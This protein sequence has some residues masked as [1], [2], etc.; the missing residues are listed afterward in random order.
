VVLV[1]QG[2][3]YIK[4]NK[5]NEIE[6]VSDLSQIR[7]FRKGMGDNIPRF[8]KLQ[9]TPFEHCYDYDHFKTLLSNIDDCKALMNMKL[10]PFKSWQVLREYQNNRELFNKK[11]THLKTL[12]LIDPDIN[13]YAYNY[14]ID[15]MQSANITYNQVKDNLDTIN[16]LGSRMFLSFLDHHRTSRIFVDYACDFKALIEWLTYTIKNR[17]RLVIDRYY[18]GNEYFNVG[19]YVDYLNSQYQMYGKIREKYPENWLTEKQIMNV[20]YTEWRTLKQ[21]AEFGLHQ[22]RLVDKVSFEDDLFKVV[23]PLTNTMILDE[24]EQQRHCV[25][26]YIDKVAQ[27]ET[28]IVFIRMKDNI[29]ESL[30]T[31][32]INNNNTICQVRGFQNRAY[33]RVEYDFM[34]KWAEAKKLTLGVPECRN[35]DCTN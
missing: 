27:G 25:A 8:K 21:N 28:H 26:S 14:I 32:E 10:N 33:N 5:T 20:K 7:H 2:Q 13:V 17:N 12:R 15:N 24:A 4:D 29:D 18:S 22:E 11:Q 30:L 31:V 1:S 19:D 6:R 16:E 35:T 3:I 34:K 23:V 9:W